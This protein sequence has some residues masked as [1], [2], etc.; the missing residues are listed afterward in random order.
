LISLDLCGRGKGS[1]IAFSRLLSVTHRLSFAVAVV[2]DGTDLVYVEVEMEGLLP[3]WDCY[4]P[5]KDFLLL[6]LLSWVYPT[7]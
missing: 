4:L 2:V 6:L 1:P 3:L 7:W 5:S